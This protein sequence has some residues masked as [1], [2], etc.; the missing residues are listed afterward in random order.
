MTH[1][2]VKKKLPDILDGLSDSTDELPDIPSLSTGKF[3]D[4]FASSTTH[5][6]EKNKTKSLL[7]PDR[8]ELFLSDTEVKLAF[9][10]CRIFSQTDSNLICD[11]FKDLMPHR[12]DYFL[13]VI[14]KFKVKLED[15]KSRLCFDGAD[16]HFNGKKYKPQQILDH[17]KS[18]YR[19]NI[20]ERL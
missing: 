20:K 13:P 15:V 8:N 3:Y 11:K 18:V 5:H 10:D 9:I 1:H 19:K 17:L 4:I 16:V 7:R 14:P 12:D 2:L 6:L